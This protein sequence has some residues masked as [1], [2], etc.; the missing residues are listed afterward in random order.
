MREGDLGAGE[1]A[2]EEKKT[3][4]KR[5]IERKDKTKKEKKVVIQSK[6]IET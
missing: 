4:E 2:R 3:R 5:G 6:S 1:R